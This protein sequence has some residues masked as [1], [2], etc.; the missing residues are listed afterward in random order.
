MTKEMGKGEIRPHYLRM[1]LCQKETFK[2]TQAIMR[3]TLK[4]RW[5]RINNLGPNNSSK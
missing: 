1:I 4:N 5:R 3:V 2:E